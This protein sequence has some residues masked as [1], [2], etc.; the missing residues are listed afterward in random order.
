MT[1]TTLCRLFT[2][3]PRTRIVAFGSSNTDRRITGMHWFDWLDL[4]IKQTFGRV[5]HCINAGVGGDT[6]EE[7]LKRFDE[8]VARYAP[9]AVIVTIGGNDAKPGGLGEATYRA[10]LLALCEKIRALDATAVL[11][12]YYAADTEAL[13]DIHG[14]RFLAFMQVIRDVAA[15]TG[16]PLV[17]HHR[18]WEP[19]RLQH[20]DLY[21]ALML[22]ALHVNALGNAIMGLDLIRAF[23]LRLDP[24]AL[25]HATPARAYQRLLD[26]LDEG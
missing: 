23:D 15:Q 21:Q 12:T 20:P 5:H 2:T 1:L 25:T 11:Q 13:G 7:L 10:N 19:L 26:T 4:G 16:T 18:R 17:D 14:P 8:D 6:T 24:A 3:E 22:D 9:H